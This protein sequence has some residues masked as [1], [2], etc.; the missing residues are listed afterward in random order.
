MNIFLLPF[1]IWLKIVKTV[2]V[3]I[4]GYSARRVTGSCLRAL[5]SQQGPRGSAA[6]ALLLDTC[7][8]VEFVMWGSSLLH[9][10]VICILFTVA[11]FNFYFFLSK[12]SFLSETFVHITRKGKKIS[13]AKDV[14]VMISIYWMHSSLKKVDN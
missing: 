13:I 11:F 10:Q 5:L 3:M 6:F 12:I 1:S 4:E 7:K 2:A 9:S 14:Y 8:V